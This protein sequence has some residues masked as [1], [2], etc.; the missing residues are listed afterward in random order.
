MINVRHVPWEG[1]KKLLQ[2]NVVNHLLSK[3]T[4][5]TRIRLNLKVI[6]IQRFQVDFKIKDR[7][8]FYKFVDIMCNSRYISKKVFE[9]TG[10][11]DS[12]HNAGTGKS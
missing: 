7:T 6:S 12:R 10:I 5:L 2:K 1:T 8:W 3:C 11:D 4:Y 9:R